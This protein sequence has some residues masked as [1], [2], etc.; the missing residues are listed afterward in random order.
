LAALGGASAGCRPAVPPMAPPPEP[1]D[2]PTVVGARQEGGGVGPGRRILVGEMCPLGAAG[3]PGLAPLLLRGVQW[4]DEPTE[5]GN[6][7]SHGEA[8][9]FSVF[10]VDGKRAGVFDPVGIAEVGLPQTVAAGSY[11]GSGPCT[12]AA[13][14]GARLEEPACQAATRGCG[15]AVTLLGDVAGGG[16]GEWQTGGACV[17]ADEL[18]IDVDNDGAAEAFPLAALLDGLRAPSEVVEPRA[19]A[20]GSCAPTFTVFGLRIAPPAEAGKAADPRYLV[21]IDVLGVVDFDGDGLKEVVLSLRYPDSRSVVVYSG[22]AGGA[23]EVAGGGASLRLI[24]E[25]STWR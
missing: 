20:T 4:T 10:G 24:G 9:K 8:A 2:G 11:V 12:R 13:G 5:V 19:Q 1:G 23:G 22:V 3:R 15:L 14:N 21:L 17:S 25:A 16:G 18:A 7:I 6:A